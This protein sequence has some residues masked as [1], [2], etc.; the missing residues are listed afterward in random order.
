MKHR[1]YLP[2]VLLLLI[3]TAQIYFAKAKDLSPWKGGGFGMF[4]TIDTPDSRAVVAYWIGAGGKRIE[5]DRSLYKAV[6]LPFRSFPGPRGF[7]SVV[8]KIKSEFPRHYPKEARDPGVL[9]VEFWRF[10]LDGKDRLLRK[11][12]VLSYSG[13]LPV[14]AGESLDS[15]KL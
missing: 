9:H 5:V 10:S 1:H 14:S 12:L 2:V 8:E 15:Q 3:S 11:A 6:E 7:R 4:S 13:P